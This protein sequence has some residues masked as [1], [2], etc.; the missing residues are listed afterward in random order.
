S[1][2]RWRQLTM[3]TARSTLRAT[4]TRPRL[5]NRSPFRKVVDHQDKLVLMIAIDDF[6]IDS[7]FGHA[8]RDLAQLSGFILVQ[9]LHENL[10]LIQDTNAGRFECLAGSGSIDEEEMGATT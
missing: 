7:R 2:C 10:S 1:R 3:G 4:L 6:D 9:S 8:A 5:R